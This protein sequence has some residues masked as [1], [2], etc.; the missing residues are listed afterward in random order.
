MLLEVVNQFFPPLGGQSFQADDRPRLFAE[1]IM[2]FQPQ[3][4]HLAH[5]RQS[6]RVV[7]YDL[8]FGL[9]LDFQRI[10]VAG[11]HRGQV[12]EQVGSAAFVFIELDCGGGS[13]SGV[14]KNGSE[15]RQQHTKNRATRHNGL[16]L[17]WN[18]RELSERR[19]L[20]RIGEAV[21][22]GNPAAGAAGLS[23]ILFGQVGSSSPV[24]DW[25]FFGSGLKSAH[26]LNEGNDTLGNF[27]ISYDNTPDS[28]KAS[29]SSLG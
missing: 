16:P 12:G 15:D 3:H 6:D 21:A 27:S 20:L 14:H 7:L 28:G 8:S 4:F 22:I 11:C 17:P 23:F 24:F 2:I 18:K 29:P 19:L 9:D 13:V 5:H 10:R 26:G 25:R 1:Q